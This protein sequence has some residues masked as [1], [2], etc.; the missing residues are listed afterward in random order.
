MTCWMTQRTRFS[1]VSEVWRTALEIVNVEDHHGEVLNGS[2]SDQVD[3]SARRV[4]Y[5]T[6]THG[7]ETRHYYD[8]LGYTYRIIHPDQR[9]EWFFRDSAKKQLGSAVQEQ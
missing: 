6:D 8:S 7:Q 9:S 5:V 4:T 2:R 1:P 3:R